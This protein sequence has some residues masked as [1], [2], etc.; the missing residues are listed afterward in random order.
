MLKRHVTAIMAVEHPNPT[1]CALL[2]TPDVVV[3]TTTVVM[4]SS[5]V[6]QAAQPY[7]L[8]PLCAPS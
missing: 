8:R 1:G 7:L 6:T 2:S 3:T 5:A 4:Y